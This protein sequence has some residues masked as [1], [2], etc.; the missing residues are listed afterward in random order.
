MPSSTIS[1][2]STNLQERPSGDTPSPSPKAMSISNNPS[3]HK[4]KVIK[5]SSLQIQVSLDEVMEMPKLDLENPT[6]EQI[7]LFQ[8]ILVKKE[9]TR[10]A[11]KRTS[12]GESIT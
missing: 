4:E 9:E 2:Y 11:K 7:I 6:L 5:D 10:R 8:E 12:T 1:I 3:P